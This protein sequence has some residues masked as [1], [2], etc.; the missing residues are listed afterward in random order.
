[1]SLCAQTC[2]RVLPS[3]IFACFP[4]G[5]QLSIVR[6]IHFPSSASCSFFWFPAVLSCFE[7]NEPKKC[8][9]ESDP[10]SVRL[11]NASPYHNAAT[12][13]FNHLESPCLLGLSF[14][15]CRFTPGVLFC[16]VLLVFY[17]RWKVT[18]AVA[19]CSASITLQ[20]CFT[21]LLKGRITLL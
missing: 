13:H 18:L 11:Q 9:S 21:Y 19:E 6:L 17:S 3:S 20:L 12:L 14:F 2:H 15:F 1:M 5:V 8:T 16:F 7:L 10:F 4:F